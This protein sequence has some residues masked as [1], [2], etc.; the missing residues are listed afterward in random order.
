M[1]VTDLSWNSDGNFLVSC[2][3][4]QT[5]RCYSDVKFEK[6]HNPNQQNGYYETSRAQIHGYDINTVGCRKTTFQK[7]DLRK[8]CDVI[9][10]GADEK[11]LRALEPPAE[12][13][14]IINSMSQQSYHLYFPDEKEE[15]EYLNLTML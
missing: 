2:S 15:K 14:N 10:C 5:T 11:I 3:K 6:E 8:P 7:D 1:K 4:D 9:I 12:F 13:I